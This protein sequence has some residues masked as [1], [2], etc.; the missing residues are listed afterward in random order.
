MQA[1]QSIQI[2]FLQHNAAYGGLNFRAG[3][4]AGGMRCSACNVLCSCYTQSIQIEGLQEKD[5][6]GGALVRV[7]GTKGSV[8]WM[9]GG[10]MATLRLCACSVCNVL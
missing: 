4:G 1:T 5:G 10:S 3:K 2:E 6:D 9:G 7:K 8:G